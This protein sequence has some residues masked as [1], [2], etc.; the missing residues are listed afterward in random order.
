[1]NHDDSRMLDDYK[2]I[3]LQ[4]GKHVPRFSLRVENCFIVDAFRERSSMS[5]F[6]LDVEM[7]P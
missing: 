6:Y 5:K 3:I 1:M 4:Q 7:I 2:Y